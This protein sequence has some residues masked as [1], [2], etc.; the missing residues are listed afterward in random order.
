M[1]ADNF[2]FVEPSQEDIER[3]EQQMARLASLP[4]DQR[5]FIGV[6]KRCVVCGCTFAIAG[7]DDRKRRTEVCSD[8]ECQLKLDDYNAGR[9][10][11]ERQYW[12]NLNRVA[13]G[14]DAVDGW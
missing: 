2:A 9:E 4:E 6:T 10:H 8:E 1:S 11:E 5:I 14:E 3:F 7:T 12:R 13:Y